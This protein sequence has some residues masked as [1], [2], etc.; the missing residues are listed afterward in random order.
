[1]KLP[2]VDNIKNNYI[3]RVFYDHV[4]DDDLYWHKDYCDRLIEIKSGE[5]WQLQM[6]NELPV[7]L[8]KDKIY[9]IPKETWH[10][11]IK[12]TDN[13]ILLIKEF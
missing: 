8:V 12:G 6:E 7:T 11:I 13:L 2:Y 1:M 9:P 5:N 4:L 3:E 10:R